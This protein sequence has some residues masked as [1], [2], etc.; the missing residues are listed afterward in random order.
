MNNKNNINLGPNFVSSCRDIRRSSHDDAISSGQSGNAGHH[1]SRNSFREAANSSEASVNSNSEDNDSNSSSRTLE[2]SQDSSTLISLDEPKWK[3]NKSHSRPLSETVSADDFNPVRLRS[4]SH[5]QQLRE[6]RTSADVY[7]LEEAAKNIPRYAAL[8][9]SPSPKHFGPNSQYNPAQCNP[10][11]GIDPLGSMYANA[12]SS[13]MHEKSL[14]NL[15]NYQ[16]MQPAAFQQRPNSANLCRLGC[17]HCIPGYMSCHSSLAYDPHLGLNNSQFCDCGASSV[18][19]SLLLASNPNLL[20]HPLYAPQTHLG[21]SQLPTRKV[22]L[23]CLCF[24]SR[25]VRS[26]LANRVLPNGQ[27]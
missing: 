4:L 5:L 20:A 17:D 24:I 27:F 21:H 9:P 15:A 25:N 14:S 7:L 10:Y 2:Y 8:S 6:H 26:P 3:G 22:L 18:P 16:M 11:Y 1:L 19:N 13:H 23:C 12:F